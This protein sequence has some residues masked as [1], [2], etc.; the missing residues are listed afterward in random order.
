MLHRVQ[1]R[2]GVP[3]SSFASR[4]TVAATALALAALLSVP[5]TPLRSPAAAQTPSPTAVIEPADPRTDETPPG[6]TGTPLIAA[7]AVL[8]VGALAALGTYLY[9]RVVARR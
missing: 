8:V 5:A 3:P 9:V 6:L 7:L 2:G 1:K 4:V